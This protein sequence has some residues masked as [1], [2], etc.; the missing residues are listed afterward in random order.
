MSNANEGQLDVLVRLEDK[1]ARVMKSNEHLSN[2]W[3]KYRY[4]LNSI[5][6]PKSW[7]VIPGNE[8]EIASRALLIGADLDP[9]PEHAKVKKPN[10]KLTTPKDVVE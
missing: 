9:V 4:A 6:H 5:A 3:R 1:L 7:G 8:I 2:E 10:T